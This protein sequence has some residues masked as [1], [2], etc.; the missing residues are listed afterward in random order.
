[1]GKPTTEFACTA[2][3]SVA[4]RFFG[5]C[6]ACG[7]WGTAEER[8]I[9]P[10]AAAG[11]GSA[12]AIAKSGGTGL[13]AAAPVKKLAEHSPSDYPRFSTGIHELDRVLG[14]G[15]VPGA[16]MILS[17]EPGAGKSTLASSLIDNL[18]AAGKRVCYVAGE[19]SGE[20]IRL[21]TDRMG[22]SHTGDID[23]MAETEVAAICAR[24]AGGYDFAVIDSIQTVWDAELSGAPGSVAI[25]KEVGQA[26]TR[27]AKQTGCALL[28]IG[29]VTKDGSLAGPRHLEHMVDVVLSMEGERTTDHR[30][31]RAVKNRFGATHELGVFEMTELGLKEV[32]DPSALFE[33]NPTSPIPGVIYCP[34]IEGTRPMVVEVQALAN[35]T[36]G[37]GGAM[38]RPRGIDRNRMDLLVAVL[39]RRAGHALSLGSYDLYV[40]VSGGLKIEDPAL[41]LA[42]C[43]ALASAVTDRPIKPGYVAFGEVALTGEIRAV[44][45]SERRAGEARRLG[46]PHVV[47]N[48]RDSRDSVGDLSQALSAV[49]DEPGNPAPAP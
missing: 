14:G 16:A 15:I 27:T 6:Q 41:D 9:Q 33:R 30:V 17:A 11:R 26:L 28:I 1:M 45:Q 31:L 23:V 37:G 10:S 36:P 24:L 13:T 43:A 49:L 5:Q 29:Q 44:S 21:R 46:W 12:R 25:V 8:A 38:R 34:V 22:L 42:V 3:G 47:S 4:A 2:C 40:Q 32:G 35:P 19:E 39:S 7:E 48:L 20:Q 18:A